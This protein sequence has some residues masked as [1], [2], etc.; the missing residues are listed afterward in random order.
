LGT[1]TFGTT[2][3]NQVD[4]SGLRMS[5]R[6][7]RGGGAAP[8]TLSLDIW[9]MTLSDMNALST[10]GLVATT[11]RKNSVLVRAGD[12]NSMSTVFTGTIYVA[13][14]DLSDQPDVRFHVEAAAILIAQVAPAKTSSWVGAV[15]VCPAVSSRDSLNWGHSDLHLFR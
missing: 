10:L 12:A 9:G 13:Y 14:A 11:Y 5:A 7:N 2:G 6:I 1:G 3:Q 15:D 8:A 4:I